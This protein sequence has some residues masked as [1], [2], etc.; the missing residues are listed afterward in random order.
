M[1]LLLAEATVAATEAAEASTD[2]ALRWVPWVLLIAAVVAAV[3]ALLVKGI[4]LV[5]HVSGKKKG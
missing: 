1:F 5:L 2:V 3:L 4:Y